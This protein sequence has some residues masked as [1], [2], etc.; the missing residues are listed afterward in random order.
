M[1]L[2]LFKLHI[3]VMKFY[4]LFVVLLV[5]TLSTAFIPFE[6]AYA[7]DKGYILQETYNCSSPEDCFPRM[8]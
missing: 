8:P 3:S 7:G 4:V 1:V 2:Y 5:S 6:K